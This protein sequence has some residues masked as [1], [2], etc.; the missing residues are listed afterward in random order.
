RGAVVHAVARGDG[1]ALADHARLLAAHVMSDTTVGDLTLLEHLGSEVAQ[2][3]ATDGAEGAPTARGDE[4]HRHV[5]AGRH[6]GHAGTDLYHLA[7]AL[8]SP[9]DREHPVD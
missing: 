5:V 2:R 1:G 3:L 6:G 8:V 7:R 9:D 4:R